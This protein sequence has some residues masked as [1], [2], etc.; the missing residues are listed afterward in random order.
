MEVFPVKKHDL[1]IIYNQL[2]D[3]YDLL[4]T[5]TFAL[6][7]GYTWDMKVI[8]GKSVF[9]TFDLYKEDDDDDQFVFSVVYT[10]PRKPSCYLFDGKY[11]HWHP[12]SVEQ[13]IE[14]VVAFMEGTHKFLL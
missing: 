7:C 2:K 14:D 3:R 11:T 9:G 1:D 8:R 4:L 6:N 12:Q 5:N 13:A 10:N